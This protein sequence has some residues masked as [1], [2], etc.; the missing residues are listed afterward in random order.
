MQSVLGGNRTEVD[1][2]KMWGIV[3]DK[4]LFIKMRQRD[5]DHAARLA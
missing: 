2:G 3:E 4:C 5:S 1:E